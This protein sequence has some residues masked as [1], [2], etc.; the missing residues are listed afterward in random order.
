MQ[1]AGQ[2]G[3][4]YGIVEGNDSAPTSQVVMVFFNLQRSFQETLGRWDALR[5]VGRGWGWPGGSGAGDPSLTQAL[6]VEG[7]ARTRAA[8]RGGSRSSPLY[9]ASPRRA[10]N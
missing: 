2:L 10:S 4:L 3:G 5:Q 8:H 6:G 9:T 1:L 7:L